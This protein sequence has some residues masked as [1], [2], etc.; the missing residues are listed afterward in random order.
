MQTNTPSKHY[1]LTI[2]HENV[3]RFHNEMD[4]DKWQAWKNTL[5]ALKHQYIQFLTKKKEEEEEGDDDD[6]QHHF[7]WGV[8]KNYFK[9]M[10]F[11]PFFFSF[12]WHQL[13]NDDNVIIY[14]LHKLS[15]II[16]KL[17]IESAACT[18]NTD[19]L[20]NLGT[21][22]RAARLPCHFLLL[23]AANTENL[24]STGQENYIN[25]FLQADNTLS[26]ASLS[27][28]ILGFI[29]PLNNLRI[30]LFNWFW[31]VWITWAQNVWEWFGRLGQDC[32]G[33]DTGELFFEPM[34]VILVALEIY[35]YLSSQC[36]MISLDGDI[37]CFLGSTLLFNQGN[38][39]FFGFYFPSPFHLQV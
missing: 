21:A 3:N 32:T 19:S 39:F 12:P 22:T 28:Q 8:H 35:F 6:E 13:K 29:G 11:S 30:V 38:G 33:S 23:A 5:Q 18:I 26:V 15:S 14:S 27:R 16:Q 10:F 7:N 37:S 9:P 4:A 2:R 31:H 34:N 36:F 1:N 24:M 25:I 20:F 17:G